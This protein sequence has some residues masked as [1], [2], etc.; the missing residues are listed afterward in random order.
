[1]KSG[2]RQGAG[3]TSYTQKAK[4]APK[5]CEENQLFSMTRTLNSV[6]HVT[7]I[8]I[9]CHLYSLSAHPSKT[10]QRCNN[11]EEVEGALSGISRQGAAV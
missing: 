9:A 2:V 3:V 8:I 7:S 5:R 4:A 6:T 10:I 1:M 11:I